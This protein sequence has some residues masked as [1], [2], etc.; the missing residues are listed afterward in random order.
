M[1]I[2]CE[3]QFLRVLS[4]GK[5]SNL[6]EGFKLPHDVPFSV[7]VRPKE[8]TIDADIVINAKCICDKEASALPVP[9]Y[10]WTPAEIV[11]IAPNAI[12]LD[13]YDVYWG[14][15]NPNI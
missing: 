13:S 11:E 12:S 9:L 14:A 3:M 4:H 15:G 8:S 1:P 5:L 6:S 2:M 10:D 7:Y